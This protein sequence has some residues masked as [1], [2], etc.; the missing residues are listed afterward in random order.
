MRHYYGQIQGW[1]S[2][3][4]L[5]EE[6]IAALPDGAVMVEVG[7]WKGKSAA[8]AGVEIINSHKLIK[9][10]AVDHFKGAPNHADNPDIVAGRLETIARANLKPVASVVT[11]I[12]K[13]SIEAAAEFKDASVDFLML[14]GTHDYASV[15]ADL[16]A[17]LPKLKP[18]ALVAGDDANWDK[19][20]VQRAARELL[21]EIAILLP[22]TK[23]AHWQAV[24]RIGA[25]A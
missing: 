21:G 3:K 13:P 2:Y 25:T 16:L 5:I 24:N 6:V 11:V 8:F 17:W 7:T 20:G 4:A 12:A 23:G 9:F 1:F 14:D 15:R 10:F 22:G 18:G 19:G